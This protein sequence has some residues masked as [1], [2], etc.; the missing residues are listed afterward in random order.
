MFV[1]G[2]MIDREAWLERLPLRRHLSDVN[3]QV[4][5]ITRHWLR[6]AE[7]AAGDVEGAEVAL[8]AIGL[9]WVQRRFGWRPGSD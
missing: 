7:R 9:D 5:F 6:A 1:W 8:G 3:H 4:D 2:E